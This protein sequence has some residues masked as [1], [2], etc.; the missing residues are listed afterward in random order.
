M[1]QGKK[2]GCHASKNGYL[3]PKRLLKKNGTSKNTF[4]GQ[5]P[6]FSP[7]R[8][9]SFF[10]GQ[11]KSIEESIQRNKSGCSLSKNGYWT[12]KA[13]SKHHFAQ[14]CH[15]EDFLLA[16]FYHKKMLGVSKPPSVNL[17]CCDNEEICVFLCFGGVLWVKYPLFAGG[18]PLFFH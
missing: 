5:M 2:S 18:H 6:N 7:E 8:S 17:F 1:I 15:K 14:K 3:T 11:D 12:P 9:P 13:P 10:S 16:R 4:W